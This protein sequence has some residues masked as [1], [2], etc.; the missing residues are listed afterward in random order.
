MSDKLLTQDEHFQFTYQCDKYYN[1]WDTPFY[2]ENKS[3]LTK[4][5]PELVKAIED[6]KSQKS[7]VDLLIK[8][9]DY[10]EEESKY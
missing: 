1:P 6:L 10:I 2:K 9:I 5:N 7:I 4:T 3:R 8:S